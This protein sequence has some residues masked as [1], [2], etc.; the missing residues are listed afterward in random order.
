MKSKKKEKIFYKALDSPKVKVISKNNKVIV[1][2]V[3][4]ATNYLNNFW[5]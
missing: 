2:A 3:C 5:R 1:Q 4:N